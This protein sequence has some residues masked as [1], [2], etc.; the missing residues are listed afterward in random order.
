MTGW[1]IVVAEPYSSIK[2]AA[3]GQ[4]MTSA[5]IG[6][7]LILLV[8]VLA[9]F[10]A[11]R[12][13]APILSITDTAEKIAGGNLAVDHLP[14]ASNDEL[15]RLAASFNN[16]VDKLTSLLSK[17][18]ENADMVAN[19][20]EQL[21]QSSEQSAE[22]ANLIATSITEVAES[23][24]KQKSAVDSA[25]TAAHN[26]E[27]SLSIASANSE[28]AVASARDTMQTAKDGKVTIERAV[29]GMGAL[30]D[31]VHNA[32]KVI[33]SL[34][35]QSQEIG[36][37]VDTISGI[38]AQ[39]NLLAL[40][41]AIE[42]ARAG[43]YG[44]GFAVV[45]DEVRKL[46]EQSGEAAEKISHL[47]TDVQ[48]HTEDAVTTMHKGTEMT[49]E[50]VT[51]VA[52][53]GTAFGEIVLQIETL[54]EKVIK[55]M[56]A[57]KESNNDSRKIVEAVSGIEQVAEGVAKE[58]QTVSAATEE[59]SASIEEVA[60]SGRQL[61]NMASELQKLVATFKLKNR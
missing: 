18:N 23:A 15:G 45:A 29:N 2:S 50:S 25:L 37:I 54:T 3:Y 36:Q 61:A 17:T 4:A 5:G 26:M 24:V 58:T 49:S 42:A 32:E 38:A 21:G 16:M 56:D 1:V 10:I 53:A 7:V 12:A 34:G 48:K 51:G 11:N 59:Q 47:I 30:E 20:S 22:A 28:A 40:N 57:V 46:A 41:A 60:S 43:E 19:S 13:A 14:V 35:E 9:F 6:I 44:R 31:A 8:A 33:R 55:A 39:T 52:K 27:D